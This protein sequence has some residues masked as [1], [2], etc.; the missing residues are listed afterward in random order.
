MRYNVE[1]AIS[2]AN[3]IKQ[4]GFRVFL[5]KS[6]EYGFITDDKGERVMSFS[7]S[8]LQESLSGNYGPPS[9]ES[10]TGW[11]LQQ[12]PSQLQTAEDVRK[13]LYER[14]PEYC[15]KGWKHFTT[16]QQHLDTYGTSSGY[17]EL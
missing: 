1:N 12:R 9:R 5:A 6:K 17:Q 10:G 4:L 14:P 8:G 16:L 3:H 11:R 7:F 13:A 15:G 2:F